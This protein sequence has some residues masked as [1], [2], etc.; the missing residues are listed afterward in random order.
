VNTLSPSRPYAPSGYIPTCR[1]PETVERSDVPDWVTPDHQELK[2]KG[3]RQK[4]T[5]LEF[6]FAP[7][8]TTEHEARNY[9]N[10]P[11]GL[12]EEFRAYH[13]P[14]HSGME[15]M[16]Y[17]HFATYY[18]KV[19]KYAFPPAEQTRHDYQ[20]ERRHLS[21]L[22]GALESDGLIERWSFRKG[23]RWFQVIRL[24]H[25]DES[26]RHRAMR[27]QP[28]AREIL[29]AKG[30]SPIAYPG[31]WMSVWNL[32]WLKEEAKLLTP[33]HKLPDY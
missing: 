30:N 27:Q 7:L 8:A 28:S 32:T 14:N 19:N 2:L 16:L 22:R 11:K 25:V 23:R 13:Y 4:Q 33:L 26:G 12:T 18:N 24:P 1:Y 20:I 10:W 21:E 17:E 15:I 5:P 29:A 6:D 9:L 3:W 31:D